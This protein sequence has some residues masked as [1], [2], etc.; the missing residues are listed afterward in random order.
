M[1]KIIGRELLSE[2]CK[3]EVVW[4]RELPKEMDTWVLVINGTRF[5]THNTANGKTGTDTLDGKPYDFKSMLER[6]TA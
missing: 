1:E 6:G 4:H 2:K 5:I 3:R